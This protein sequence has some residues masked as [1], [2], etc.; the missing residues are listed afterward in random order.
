MPEQLSFEFGWWVLVPIIFF[1]ALGIWMG[2]TQRLTVYRNYTDVMIVGLLVILPTA[3][4]GFILLVAHGE[5]SAESD[6]SYTFWL[7]MGLA[8][9]LTVVLLIIVVRTWRDNPNPLKMLLALYVK[10][11]T[12]ILFFFN[13]VGIF[14]GADRKSRR[15]STM[16]TLIMTPLLYGLVVDKSG[17][18]KL[19]ARR[20]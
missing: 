15:N 4:L 19:R 1:Y 3:V 6:M 20:R 7:L 2:N 11:P 17:M 10:I 16:W 12:G 8:A 9:V 13:F 5:T 18:S 14:K